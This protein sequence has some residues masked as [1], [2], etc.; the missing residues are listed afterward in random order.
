[1]TES[2]EIDISILCPAWVEALP[3]VEGLCRRAALAAFYGEARNNGE[4]PV[5]ASLVLADDDFIRPLNKKYRG[6]DKPTNVLSFAF[7]ESN[8]A[9][10]GHPEQTPEM[11][12][13]IVLAFETANSEASAGDKSLADHLSHLIVHGMLHLLGYDHKT[14]PQARVMERLETRALARIDIAA[15]YK[16]IALG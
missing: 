11:L 5:E 7:R 1:M 12:G 6:Q 4:T 10:P 9:S 3:S 15:P 14:A 13:D 16:D 8:D 2:L